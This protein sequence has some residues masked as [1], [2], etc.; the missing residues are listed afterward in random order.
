MQVKIA[1]EEV[2]SKIVEWYS[3]IISASYEEAKVI[4]KEVTQLLRHMEEDDKVL[5]YYSLVDFRHNLFIDK[6]NK[7]HHIVGDLSFIETDVDRYLKYLYY[8]IG[9]QYEYTQERYR[10][11]VKMFRKA[12]RLLEYVNDEAEE[13]E[14]YMYIGVAYYRLNQYLFATSYLEQAETIFNRLNYHERALNCKQVLGAIFSELHQYE[15]GDNLLTEALEESTYPVTTGIILRALALSKIRQTN[16]EEAVFFFE[17]ALKIKEHR[18]FYNGAKT[19]TDLSHTLFKLG[20]YESAKVI[21]KKAKVN[22]WCFNNSEF[23]ARCKYIEG[24]Y[25]MSDHHLIKEALEDLS[26]LGM[27]YE[28]C[29]LAEEMIEISENAKDVENALGYYRIAYKGKLDQNLIGDDQV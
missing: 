17:S 22:V 5:A 9:G 25:L 26:R 29:E 21:F 6:S 13:S 10:S 16:Y 3:C 7:G 20:R 28:V 27:Y 14:F 1:S 19:L 23:K 2:G 15:K 11:A 8:F 12:E 24:L 4:K 18:E